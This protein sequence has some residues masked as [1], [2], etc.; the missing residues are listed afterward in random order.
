MRDGLSVV[1][2][3]T[4]IPTY[5]SEAVSEAAESKMYVF[6]VVHWLARRVLW[7]RAASA[8]ELMSTVHE[9]NHPKPATALWD[10]EGDGMLCYPV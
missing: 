9:Q 2:Q 8:R 6:E 10:R 1:Y 4:S 5:A 3:T 7:L